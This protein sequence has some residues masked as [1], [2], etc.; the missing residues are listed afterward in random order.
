M[1]PIIPH[2]RPWILKEDINAV[3]SALS[4]KSVCSWH[5]AEKLSE[6]LE[7]YSGFESCRLYASGT[8]ALRAALLHS[9]IPEGS[10]I[11]IPSFT[12]KGVLYGVLA[13]GYRP[14][15][16]DCDDAGLM[17]GDVA[18]M[19]FEDGHIS[20]CIAVHQF[21]LVNRSIEHL[22]DSMTVIEDCSHVPPKKYL[23]G[24]KG[25]FGSLEGTKL[26]GA[27]EGGYLLLDSYHPDAADMILGNRL[28]DIIAVLAL[29]Q[30]KRL[31][32]NIQKRESIALKYKKALKGF[33][34][35]Y[36]E[37]AAW[38]RFLLRMDSLDSV[39]ELIEEAEQKGITLRRPIMP[40]SLHKYVNEFIDRCPNTEKLWE[41]VVSIPLYPDLTE[42]EID[43]ITQFLIKKF[44]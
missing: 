31:N 1:N 25:V 21:G 36:G 29:C 5:Y 8:L 23:S 34:P 10:G 27:G 40:C 43:I 14:F 6:A 12:C 20:A 24:S 11:G 22:T 35:I 26:L 17:N 3:N 39:N 9:D 16:I 30:L 13:A 42:S 37:R 28:S 32:E 15:I 7:E 18:L 38:F 41:T 4:E 44:S 19:A 2:L 33:Q